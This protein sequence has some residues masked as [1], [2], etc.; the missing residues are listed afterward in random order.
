MEKC[1]S[2]VESI[3]ETVT[4]RLG[5]TTL[6]KEQDAI[7]SYVAGRD[8]S[9]RRRSVTE[10]VTERPHA[11]LGYCWGYCCLP[12]ICNQLKG[13]TGSIAVIIYS[14]LAGLVT[15]LARTS[16]DSSCASEFKDSKWPPGNPLAPRQWWALWW[17]I[18]ILLLLAQVTYNQVQPLQIKY[19]ASNHR[20]K[21]INY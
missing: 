21:I 5:Y 8:V 9:F 18:I 10:P 12:M 20:G 4:S 17:C 13:R 2:S 16:S 19:L 7:F 3:V 6:K 15:R 11:T 14:L 1:L